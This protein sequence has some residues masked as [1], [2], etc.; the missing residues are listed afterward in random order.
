MTE[1]TADLIP[2]VSRL[3]EISQ[4]KAELDAEEKTLKTQLRSQFDVGTQLTVNG[5]PVIAIQANRRF[6]ADL[7]K[8][9]IPE[10]LLPLCTVTTIDSKRA[11]EA[12]PPAIYKACMQDYEPRVVLL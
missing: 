12:L 3:A 2:L 8:T 7:A 5:S 10:T 11:K 6:S 1:A 4:A 9:H